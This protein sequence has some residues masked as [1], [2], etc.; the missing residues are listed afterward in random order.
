MDLNKYWTGIKQGDEKMLRELFMKMNVA[1]CRYA[2]CLTE[3]R[4]VAEE[5]VQDVFIKLWQ[6]RGK[7]LIRNSLRSYLYRSVRN[8]SINAIYSLN[9]KKAA[10]NKLLSGESWEIIMNMLDD[11]DYI[12]E[13][14]EAKEVE[15]MINEVIKSLPEQCR[16]IF[17][18]SRFQNKSRGD[19]ARAFKI[20]ENTVKVQIH[21]AL[22]RIR[23]V[24]FPE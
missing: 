15:K 20:S 7:I 4:F 11:D 2:F 12:I 9:T 16:K 17:E 22:C 21:K 3:D 19:I 23:E 8:S 24:L 10:V 14:I 18:M 1:L 13:K 6:D 5:I